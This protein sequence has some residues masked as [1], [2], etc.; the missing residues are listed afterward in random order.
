MPFI[1][2]QPGSAIHISACTPERFLRAGCKVIRQGHGY[3][4]VFNPDVYIQELMR[5]GKSLTDA[6]EG[7]CSGCIEVGAFGKE[8]YVLTG[9]LNVPKIL[10]VTLHNGVD[11]ISG[12]KVGL[13][14]GEA[15][16]FQT[17]EG[18]DWKRAKLILSRHSKIYIRLS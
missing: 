6:R 5:Q 12:R 15:D 18:S 17:F 1:S 4:S 3:P 2:L 9:Y 14:T 7:G 16:S 11:P 8:A 13:E 10:E